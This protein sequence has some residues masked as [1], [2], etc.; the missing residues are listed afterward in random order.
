MEEPLL[1]NGGA[2]NRSTSANDLPVF[3]SLEK[4][5][6]APAE[7]VT[8]AMIRLTTC[9]PGATIGEPDVIGQRE[10]C[11]QEMRDFG[12]G[13]V[14]QRA[15]SGP[16]IRDKSKAISPLPMDS[17]S[18]QHGLSGGMLVYG[19]LSMSVFIE[20]SLGD[21]SST[22]LSLKS[23]INDKI[24][25]LK[26]NVARFLEVSPETFYLTHQAKILRESCR[27]KDYPLREGA[28]VHV[29]FRL[30]GGS[31]QPAVPTLAPAPTPGVAAAVSVKMPE[32]DETSPSAWFAILEAQFHLAGVTVS[33]TKFYHALSKLPTKTVSNLDNTVLQ[34]QDYD[35]LN[36]AVTAYHEA[37][38]PELLDKFLSDHTL[39]GRPSHF[40]AEMLTAANKVGVKEDLVR[41]KFQQA[42]PSTI[43][44]IIATQKTTPL[45][46]LGKLADELMAVVP[47]G[48]GAAA[49]TMQSHISGRSNQRSSERSVSRSR[50]WGTL[51]PFYN[52][53]KP[54]ICRGHI[55]YGPQSRTCREWCKWPDK[56][57]CKVE[58]S[59][60]NTP[61]NSRASSPAPSENM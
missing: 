29:Q 31:T 48:G 15:V 8:T 19:G 24:H 37:T 57:N 17:Q 51:T 22:F 53:Q 33:Q 16:D 58:K 28:V 60:Q 46:D 3:S 47:S 56:R 44:P 50:P 40:L 42:L 5:V 11:G 25:V 38:K 27:M 52:D 39:T 30:L 43:G 61:R 54:K 9:M 13:V 26:K 21:R 35:K 45:A 14:D 59:R 36:D 12:D 1:D 23:S 6:F 20:C 2:N 32:F 55:F 49:V 7:H 18:S 4:D 10:P 41:H 34:S